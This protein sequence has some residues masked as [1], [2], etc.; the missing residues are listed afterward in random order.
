MATTQERTYKFSRAIDGSRGVDTWLGYGCILKH[1]GDWIRLKGIE[2]EGGTFSV[3]YNYEKGS[4]NK[5]PQDYLIELQ[6]GETVTIFNTENRGDHE[7]VWYNVVVAW[8]APAPPVDVYVP[9]ENGEVVNGDVMEDGAPPY[10]TPGLPVAAQRP[11]L[12]ALAQRFPFFQR[13][14]GGP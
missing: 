2:E 6:P 4:I 3:K 11:V 9:D 5:L 10:P 7:N 12:T 1:S 14:M 8:E 13:F